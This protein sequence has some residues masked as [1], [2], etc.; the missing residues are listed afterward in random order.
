MSYHEVFIVWRVKEHDCARRLR[1]LRMADFVYYTPDL[2]DRIC[3]WIDELCQAWGSGCFI[4]RQDENRLWAMLSDGE[5]VEVTD[6][7][8]NVFEFRERIEEAMG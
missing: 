1:R 2:G 6:W 3:G 4:S 7:G 5:Q 8:N